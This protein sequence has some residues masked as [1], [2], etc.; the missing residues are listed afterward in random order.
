MRSL[1]RAKRVVSLT[2]VAM[3]LGATFSAWTMPLAIPNRFDLAQAP[4][5]TEVYTLTLEADPASTAV[6]EVQVRISDWTR[7]TNGD[8]DW[9]IPVNG[10]RWTSDAAFAAGDVVVIRYRVTGGE[11]DLSVAGAFRT[12]TPQ[13]SGSVGGSARLD[14]SAPA[15]ASPSASVAVTR[16]IADD[17]V[18]LRVECRTGFQGLLITETYS[19]PVQLSSEEAAGGTFDTVSRSCSSWIVLSDSAVQLGP[20]E[21]RGIAFTVTTP[22]TYEGSYWSALI[23]AQPYVFEQGGMKVL[24]IAQVA[25]KVFVTAPGTE[26]LSASIADVSVIATSPL[27]VSATFV[28][29]SNVELA[30]SGYVD[31]IDRTGPLS[32]RRR[33]M[34]SR[35]CRAGRGRWRSSTGRRSG[36]WRPE[37]IKRW[38]G[39][40]TAA[41]VPSSGSAASACHESAGPI[42][43]FVGDSEKERGF[44]G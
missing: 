21:S 34:S 24:A 22:S 11:G 23:V 36:P 12:G 5:T 16:S 2:C 6:E 37:S 26:V 30:A 7:K 41:R 29:S 14:G 25:V 43:R 32:G 27:G 8:H 44:I 13:V 28:N 38:S 19:G 42:P 3:V 40:T 35:C 18:T 39:S 17:E 33:S 4:G 20:G 1:V 31:I 10:A 9:D 15:A